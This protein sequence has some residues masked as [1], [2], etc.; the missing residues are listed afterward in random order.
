[1]LALLVTQLQPQTATTVVRVL[2]PQRPERWCSPIG[3]RHSEQ[4]TTTM[5][6]MSSRVMSWS[7]SCSANVRS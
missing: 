4:E 1:M 5:Q 7:S 3:L 2:S 6:W